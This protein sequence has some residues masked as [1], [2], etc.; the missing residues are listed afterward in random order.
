MSGSRVRLQHTAPLQGRAG[1]P[2][3]A[4][5]RVRSRS[6]E[7]LENQRFQACSGFAAFGGFQTKTATFYVHP[8]F[9]LTLEPLSAS[10]LD[11]CV[12]PYR[13]YYQEGL[14]L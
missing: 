3:R 9:A 4:D 2:V 8:V 5:G 11:D 14:G 1:S 10:Y 12:F 6:G 13:V 7:D